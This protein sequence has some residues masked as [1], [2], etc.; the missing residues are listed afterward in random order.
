MR[1]LVVFE[2][3]K[4][5]KCQ[6]LCCLVC[7]SLGFIFF[8]LMPK[9]SKRKKKKNKMEGK[10]TWELLSHTQRYKSMYIFFFVKSPLFHP[11]PSPPGPPLPFCWEVCE[12]TVSQQKNTLWSCVHTKKRTNIF[13]NSCIFVCVCRKGFSQ[14]GHL[15]NHMRVHTGEK[16]YVCT[17]CSKGFSMKCWYCEIQRHFCFQIFFW[18]ISIWKCNDLYM[19]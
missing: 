6:P 7:A 10:L 19:L 3:V 16:P 13:F 5:K 8:H 2:R 12:G 4:E 15:T 1:N 18:R 17:V 9:K 11:L 14:K